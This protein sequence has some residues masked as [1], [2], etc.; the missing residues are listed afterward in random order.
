MFPRGIKGRWKRGPGGICRRLGVEN[1]LGFRA[2][3]DRAAG[4]ESGSGGALPEE[5]GAPGKRARAVNEGRGLPAYPF[6]LW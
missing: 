2:D 3:F 6:G 1:G 4:R 5:E